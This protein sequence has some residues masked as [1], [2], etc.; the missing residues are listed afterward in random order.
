MIDKDVFKKGMFALCVAFDKELTPA[1]MEVYYDFLEDLTTEQ[2]KTS[3]TQIIKTNKYSALPKPGE[4][5]EYAL[6]KASDEPLKAW[7]TTLDA[8]RSIGG[9]RTPNFKDSAINDTI[10]H[11]GG[12]IKLCDTPSAEMVWVQKEFEKFYPMFKQNPT[13]SKLIGI[14]NQY[15]NNEN[16]EIEP[17]IEIEKL[18]QQRKLNGNGTDSKEIV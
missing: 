16:L 12:W 18:N 8:I 9:Y 13:N 1:R 4:I 3:I 5:L 17:T 14:A 10:A 2:F 6:G 11:M 15:N 7:A